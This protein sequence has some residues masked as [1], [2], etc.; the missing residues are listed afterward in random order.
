MQML[1]NGLWQ[2]SG[3]PR[4]W[5][6]VYL[7]G[8]VL[9]DAGTRWAKRRILRQLR[10]RSVELVALTHCHPDHQGAAKAVCEHFGVP[11]ACHEADVP[12]M[13]GRVPMQ[14][15]NSMIRMSTRL[16]AGPSYSVGRILR[17]G[18]EV[19]GFRVVHAPGHTSGHVIFFRQSDR[20]AIAGDVLFNVS[21][22][23]GRAGLRVPPAA[24]CTDASQNRSSIRSLADLKPNM[25]CF[26]HGPPLSDPLLLEHFVGQREIALA[27]VC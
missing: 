21:F 24:F 11:L 9:I 5:F 19:G 17:D 3:F 8:D 16:W 10:G 22:V 23:T 6:N 7:V 18:D 12:A 1:A 15:N 27:P 13:E 25:V 14:P 4:D 20:I 26:G 2:L